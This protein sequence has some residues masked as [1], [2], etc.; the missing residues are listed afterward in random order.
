MSSP[1]SAPQELRRDDT[2]LV[3]HAH[4]DDES[5]Q[6]GGTLARYAA[7]GKR[8]VLITCTDGAQG[9]SP[10]GAKPG[11]PGHSTQE[12]AAIRSAELRSVQDILH[13]SDLVELRH[14]D[15]G[16][17]DDPLSIDSRSFS[18]LDPAAL[19]RQ[20]SEL[21]TQYQPAVV[22]TYPPNGLSEHPDHI[23]VHDTVT[24]AFADYR[25]QHHPQARLYYI[26]IARSRIQHLHAV[27][28]ADWTEWL[29]P[30]TISTEDSVITTAIDIAGFRES[31]RAAIA[32]HTSQA[33]A[34]TLLKI[35]DTDAGVDQA[36]FY[37]RAEPA[38]D[39]TLETD[40]FATQPE[41]TRHD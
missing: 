38:P 29:P 28:G 36:E 25:S 8:T 11:E 23:R 19:T 21:L 7:Q 16:M 4:P 18:R 30:L 14:P 12:V 9:D 35:F 41:V 40:L 27:V 1:L 22:I 32:A 39:G 26:A 34:R 17:P 20:I 10:T 6:T 2:L 31:K 24:A 15:S 5:S 33:D 3:V 37:V 13:I